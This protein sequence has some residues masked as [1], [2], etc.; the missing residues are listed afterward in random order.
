MYK[1]TAIKYNVDTGYY[2]VD[3]FIVR[4]VICKQT[5]TIWPSGEHIVNF[6]P[7]CIA[8]SSLPMTSEFH[9]SNM[10]MLKN[11]TAEMNASFT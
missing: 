4:V 1:T 8:S 6:W 5:S 11:W 9:E 2:K 10:D 7:Y 3:I